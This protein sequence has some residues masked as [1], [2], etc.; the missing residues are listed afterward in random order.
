MLNIY[1][2]YGQNARAETILAHGQHAVVTLLSGFTI[3]E[4]INIVST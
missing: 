1:V 3:N 2:V 4:N